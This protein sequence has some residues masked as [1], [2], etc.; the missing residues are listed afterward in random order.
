MTKLA[1]LLGLIGSAFAAEKPVLPTFLPGSWVQAERYAEIDKVIIGADLSIVREMSRQVGQ[2]GT[3]I[4]YPT[5]C[6]YKEIG[7]VDTFERAS[8]EEIRYY[9]KAGKSV[10]PSHSLGFAVIKV[11]LVES[12]ANFANCP[13]FIKLQ[14]ETASGRGLHYTW[15]YRDLS[16]NVILDP[17]YVTIFT[18]Q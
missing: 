4:P 14:N 15:S 5:L 18:K 13:D 6:R 9:R 2:E 12:P 3:A 10:D 1:L 16:D 8:S 7:V 11:E 17:W